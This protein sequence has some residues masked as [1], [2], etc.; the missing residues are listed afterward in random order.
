MDGEIKQ[1]SMSF[2]KLN[3]LDRIIILLGGHAAE[4]V[5]YWGV[6]QQV[7]TISGGELKWHTKQYVTDRFFR[8]CSL[9]A[10]SPL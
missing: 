3:L 8:T 6:Y 7:L 4:E 5:V 2:P 10:F 1:E 9:S